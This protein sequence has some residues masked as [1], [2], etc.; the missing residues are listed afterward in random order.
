MHSSVLFINVNAKENVSRRH[1]LSHDSPNEKFTG[2]SNPRSRVSV[3]HLIESFRSNI[4]IFLKYLIDVEI[5]IVKIFFYD[6][7]IDDLLSLLIDRTADTIKDA[8]LTAIYIGSLPIVEL[9]IS[10]FSDYPGEEQTGCKNSNSFQP[11][12][13]PLMLAC[14]CNN[15]AITE[16]LLLRGHEIVLPHRC[17][18]RC[19]ECRR[20]TKNLLSTIIKLDT[21]R[22][23]SSEPFLWLACSD[24][25]LAA[26]SL[27]HDLEVCERIEVE[28]K[29]IYNRL[30]QQVIAFSVKLIE[31][32]WNV[33]E[34]DLLL[35]RKDG[36]TLCQCELYY[37][38]V[39]V[40]LDSHMKSFLASL[41]VQTQIRE[42]WYGRWNDYG[43][44]ALI[45]FARL[46]G[47]TIFYPIL[48]V[49]YILSAGKLIES[50]NYPIARF[51]SRLTSYIVFL[52]I[53]VIIRVSG[54]AGDS[55]AN[56]SHTEN[57]I[58]FFLECYIYIYFYGMVV[59]HYCDFCNHGLARYY[60]MWWRWYDLLLLWLFSGSF[61]CWIMSMATVAQDGIA[62]LHRRHWVQYDFALIYEI[63]FGSACIMAFWRIFY[64]MQLQRSI[65]STIISIGKCASAVV[66]FIIIMF[67]VMLCFGFGINT[68]FESYTNNE[69]IDSDGQIVKMKSSFSNIVITVRNLYWSLYGYL[70]PWDYAL[71]VGNAGPQQDIMHHY[72]T[73]VTG[74]FIVAAYHITL[75]ISLLNLM[76]SLLI[77]TADRVLKNEDCEWKY[78]RLHIYFEYFE[79]YSPL[80]PPFNIVFLLIN[81][82][83]RIVHKEYK[84]VFPVSY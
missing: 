1:S 3:D 30:K 80:P 28:H 56:R 2:Q 77:Q 19:K 53:L 52:C 78:T 39:R 23:I 6:K 15:F 82:I 44:N 26:N 64:F 9:I 49:I 61:F 25:L 47:H 54:W 13:T 41:N 21:Y 42:Y 68:I 75:V 17:D 16:Y 38:R 11:H 65:G 18:C 29:V 34:V 55:A 31:N 50:F 57:P 36:A 59:S 24:P 67:V 35:R 63:C 20:E 22:A 81:S 5:S 33:Q 10:L 83:Y 37:P 46:L 4:Q 76:V 51:I 40:A 73:V 48:S 7:Q 72:I 66:L 69:M 79:W 32:C 12:I 70:A 58:K 14:I 84:F 8:L 62:V 27:A 74:E 43:E 60:E 71:V 45:N